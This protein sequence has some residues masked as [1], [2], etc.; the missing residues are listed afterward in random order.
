MLIF[1]NDQSLHF[2]PIQQFNCS[3]AIEYEI[4]I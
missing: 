4:S 3:Y 1:N 2:D